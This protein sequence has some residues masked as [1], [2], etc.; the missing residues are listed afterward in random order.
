MLC[1]Q[2]TRVHRHHKDR[3]ATG[4]RRAQGLLWFRWVQCFIGFLGLRFLLGRLEPVA[5]HG[6]RTGRPRS[7][8][9]CSLFPVFA[10]KFYDFLH[11]F[12]L[13]RRNRRAC[14]GAGSPISGAESGQCLRLVNLVCEWLVKVEKSLLRLKVRPM[15]LRHLILSFSALAQGTACTSPFPCLPTSL[16]R[17]HASCLRPLRFQLAL[18]HLSRIHHDSSP[19][20]C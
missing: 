17:L 13:S 19:A 5:S 10:S 18:H 14:T 8:R 12:C 16:S 1:R 11:A 3:K 6:L 9:L 4:F 2:C 20:P 15:L 7:V